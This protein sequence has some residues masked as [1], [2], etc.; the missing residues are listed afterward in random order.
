M[1]LTKNLKEQVLDYLDPFG[2]ILA[3]IAWAVRAS[4]N[5]ATD[6]TPAQL[7][8][9]RDMLF[10]IKA[11]INWKELSLK[12]QKLVDKA[13]LRENRNRVDYDYTVGHKVYI[14]NDGVQRKM[15][16]PKEGPFKEGPFEITDVFTNG[17]VR[18]QRGNVNERINIRRIEPHFE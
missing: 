1:F 13:N 9:G 2:E 12:K 11:L 7:V 16:C 18:I 6:A 15:D 10:N 17:T 4:Y 14:K 3:S 5:S 8:F